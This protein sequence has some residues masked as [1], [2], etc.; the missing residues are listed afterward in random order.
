MLPDTPGFLQEVLSDLY[1]RG[2]NSVIV[3]GGTSLL[4]VFITLNLWNEARVFTNTAMQIE[5]IDAPVIDGLKPSAAHTIDNDLVQFY[6]NEN[7]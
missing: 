6:F 2:I 3:E 4:N 7:K 1:N 5:G